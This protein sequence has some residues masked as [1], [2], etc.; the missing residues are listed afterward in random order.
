MAMDLE[1]LIT[2]LN[3]RAVLPDCDRVSFGTNLK[4]TSSDN[5]SFVSHIFQLQLTLNEE[6]E[7]KDTEEQDEEER[8]SVDSLSIHTAGEETQNLSSGDS[9]SRSREGSSECASEEGAIMASLFEETLAMRKM[10][11]VQSMPVE[12][13]ESIIEARTRTFVRWINGLLHNKGIHIKNLDSDLESG[14]VLIKL[15]ETLA[16]GKRIPGRLVLSLHV[17]FYLPYLSRSL[18]YK[19]YLEINLYVA[20]TILVIHVHVCLPNRC[21]YSF[22]HECRY[23]GRPLIRIQKVQNLTVAFKFLTEVEKIPLNDISTSLLLYFVITSHQWVLDI[24]FP[25]EFDVDPSIN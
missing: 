13:D 24:K 6:D 19:K 12:E 21:I 22:L 10:V 18:A 5:V 1:K 20:L 14:V 8:S 23:Y 15:L 25:I 11:Q 7:N 16:H 2:S 4:Q 17:F 3:F 9:I